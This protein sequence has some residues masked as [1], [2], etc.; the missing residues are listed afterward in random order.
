MEIKVR[1]SHTVIFLTREEVLELCKPGEQGN[2]CVWLVVGADGFECT[3]F[4]R[5]SALLKRWVNGKT[6][7]R[8][9]G[10][11]KV[12]SLNYEVKYTEATT[13]EDVIRKG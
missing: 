8:R 6:V 4:N 13:L 1:D 11:E 10:C 9:N 2:T 5:P 12:K 7:A 3:Y